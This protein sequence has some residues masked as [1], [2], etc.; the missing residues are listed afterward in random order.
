[1]AP[2]WE[3]A[4]SVFPKDTAMRYRIGSR[5]KFRNLDILFKGNETHLMLETN[6]TKL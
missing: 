2:K 1:L 3:T 6:S 4:L 5:T